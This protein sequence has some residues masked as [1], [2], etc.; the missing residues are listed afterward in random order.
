MKRCLAILLLA[1][2]CLP[3]NTSAQPAQGG[4]GPRADRERPGLHERPADRRGEREPTRRGEPLD[5]DRLEDALDTL[6][7]LHPDTKVGWIGRLEQ[8]AE[9][10]PNEAARR[11]A[12]YPRIKELMEAREKRPEEFRLHQQHAG[13]MREVFPLVRKIRQAQNRQDLQQVQALT[14]ELRKHIEGLFDVRLQLKQL[15]IERM[16]ERLR[17]AEQEIE[18]IA[19]DSETL[20]DQRLRDML[21]ADPKRPRAND[22]ESDENQAPRERERPDKPR[23]NA[24]DVP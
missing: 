24:E 11:I 14:P 8:L 23:R 18:Q 4:D 9:N 1:A 20:I 13:L 3:G 15:D 6:R 2:L 17:R 16:R 10:N 19:A 22:R 5:I 7:A 21:D 12:R